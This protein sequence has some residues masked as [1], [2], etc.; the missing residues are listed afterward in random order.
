MSLVTNA[1]STACRRFC[2]I[3]S[4]NRL[5]KIIRKLGSA[6]KRFYI[7]ILTWANSFEAPFVQVVFQ[8]GF[9]QIY[10]KYSK[11]LFMPAHVGHSMVGLVNQRAE[12]SRHHQFVVAILCSHT[13]EAVFD[14]S[15]T[16]AVE[17]KHIPIIQIHMLKKEIRVAATQR[18]LTSSWLDDTYLGAN[19]TKRNEIFIVILFCHP[20]CE[21]PNN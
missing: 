7:S 1:S 8:I 4:T 19:S 5:S 20:M 21:K 6:D 15:F 11:E 2:C 14:C 13:E 3:E 18:L 12:I 16:I 10:T 9:V 17:K